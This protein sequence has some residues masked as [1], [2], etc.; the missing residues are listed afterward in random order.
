[1]KYGENEFMEDSFEKLTGSQLVY[2]QEDNRG[3]FLDYISMIKEKELQKQLTH[4][5][6]EDFHKHQSIYSM[7]EMEET[8]NGEMKPIY[9]EQ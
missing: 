4:V 3:G 6:K 9:F 1:M 8:N 2:F 7:S 5:E